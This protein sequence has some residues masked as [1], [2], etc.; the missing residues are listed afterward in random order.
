MD[1]PAGGLQP[2]R[3]ASERAAL[4]A[5]EQA[6]QHLGERGFIQFHPMLA[7][8]LGHKAALF[9][10]LA[11]YWTRHTQKN[12]PHRKGWFYMS[13]REWLQSTGL[14]TR[15]Q[16]TARAV[17]INDGL[18]Q[19]ALAGYPPVME[20]RVDLA[21]LSQW[22][23]FNDDGPAAA[24]VKRWGASSEWSRSCLCFYKPLADLTGNVACGL[25][26]SYLMHLQRSALLGQHVRVGTLRIS[27]DDVRIAL[28]L[29][30]KVQRNARERLRRAGL[31]QETGPSLVVLNLLA[32]LA[33][34]Q[35]QDGS[36]LPRSRKAHRSPVLALVEAMTPERP[37]TAAVNAFTAGPMMRTDA[38]LPLGLLTVAAPAT[39][40]AAIGD[41]RKLAGPTALRDRLAWVRSLI[42][43]NQPAIASVDLVAGNEHVPSA[44]TKQPPLTRRDAAVA[45]VTAENAKIERTNFAENAKLEVTNFAENAKSELP[46][47]HS[48]IQRGINTN[49]TTTRVRTRGP[50]DNSEPDP[51]ACR[52]RPSPN[53]F[54]TS[55]PPASDDP[56]PP[57]TVDQDFSV[58]LYPQGLDPAFLPGVRRVL[59]KAAPAQR[60]AL[61]DEL[62]GQLR[63]QGKTI[64]NPAG[65]LMGLIRQ[66]HANNGEGGVVLAMAE[67]VAADRVHRLRVQQQIEEA[68]QGQSPST[69]VPAPLP[70]ASPAVIEEARRKLREFRADMASKRGLA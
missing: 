52:R 23:G 62:D 24:P 17:L 42:G 37:K 47:T 10:G 14:S 39:P 57:N 27:Q 55:K 45:T 19:E 43:V 9:L 50:V 21:G 54:P 15:E 22:L 8:R 36:A 16:S 67:K 13:A 70:A 12:K 59:A 29:G 58:L 11:L 5:H 61:L 2:E 18:L 64:H 49:T 1:P 46:K 38:Q 65:W 4:E 66:Q 33:C 69:S 28:C 26:L 31:L 60:Q 30:P 25:Y 51:T 48:P 32:I 7:Q 20:F 3:D 56:A 53:S 44:A 63:I 35:A 6:L 34:V 41:Q 40:V 68:A